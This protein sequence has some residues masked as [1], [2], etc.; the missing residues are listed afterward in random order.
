[1]GATRELRQ[2]DPARGSL[3]GSIPGIDVARLHG[4]TVER[5]Q[6][7][8]AI[9]RACLDTGFFCID[10]ALGRTPGYRDV[11]L[12]MQDFFALDDDDPRK[13][14]IDVSGEENTHGWMPMFQEPAYQPGTIAHLESFDCGRTRR[15][16]DDDTHRAN[17]WPAI[18]GFRE[19][20]RRLWDDLSGTGWTVLE[21]LAE[22]FELE[23]PFL[24]DRC[25]SQDLSTMRLLHYPVVAPQAEADSDVGIAAHTDFECIT[26]IMQTAPGLELTD[27]HGDW[28]DAPA[29]PGRIVV[30][31]GDMLERWS[32]GHVRATGH[33]VRSRE[34]ERYSVVLFFAVNADVSVVP[35]DAFVG[36]QGTPGYPPTTQKRHTQDE[37]DR[38]EA[39][40][41]ELARQKDA[42]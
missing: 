41:D 1:M 8:D 16:D 7:L 6:A 37:L 23:R 22:A 38:A 17:R 34:F 10:N 40:R 39:L 30:L 42:S 19:D 18:D 13:R 29:D 4:T 27:V 20:V 5:R 35:L 26:F 33:R 36:G 28:Y 32:N 2:S 25:D 12:R 24:V 9:R 21:A 15:G 31:L 3:A 14:A 11:L